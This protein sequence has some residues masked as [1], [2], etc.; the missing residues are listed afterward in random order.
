MPLLAALSQ[1]PSPAVAAAALCAG[2]GHLDSNMGTERLAGV[3]EAHVRIVVKGDVSASATQPG[4]SI[5]LANERIE[6][7]GASAQA[8]GNTVAPAR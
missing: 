2:C 3:N 1:V 7:G 6:Q 4:I 8:D 5:S